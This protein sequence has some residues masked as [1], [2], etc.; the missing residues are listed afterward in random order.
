MQETQ[1]DSIG[2]R[3]AC[4]LQPYSAQQSNQKH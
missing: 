4:W 1:Q 3:D 2:D